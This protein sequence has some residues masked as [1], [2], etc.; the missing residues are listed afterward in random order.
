MRNKAQEEHDVADD[1]PKQL[2]DTPNLLE[3]ETWGHPRGHSGTRRAWAVSLCMLV[4]FLL[5]AGGLTFGPR[6]L[7]WT[8]AGLFVVLTVYGLATHTWTD[9]SREPGIE[10]AEGTERRP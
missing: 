7:L 9:F 4:A 8:G 6:V 5:G 3:D 2:T 1:E 10:Y